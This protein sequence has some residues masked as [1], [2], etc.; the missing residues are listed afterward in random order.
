MQDPHVSCGFVSVVEPM[1]SQLA[2]QASL[3]RE[4]AW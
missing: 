2:T 1:S 3:V 4:G